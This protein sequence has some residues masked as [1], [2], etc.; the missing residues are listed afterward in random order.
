[1]W[2]LSRI[3]GELLTS[4]EGLCCG[5]LLYRQ[6]LFDRASVIESLVCHVTFGPSDR[7]SFSEQTVELE[8]CSL[9]SDLLR[10]PDHVI[11]RSDLTPFMCYAIFCLSRPCYDTHTES[12]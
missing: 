6:F 1:M 5:Q 10:V 7:T 8:V 11:K 4:G 2:A 3:A 9:Y 12:T